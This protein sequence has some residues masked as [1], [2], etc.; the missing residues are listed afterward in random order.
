M[1]RRK[2][3]WCNIKKV[4]LKKTNRKLVKNNGIVIKDSIRKERRL[5]IKLEIDFK[6][7]NLENECSVEKYFGATSKKYI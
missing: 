7:I 6:K 1:Q 4:H 3:L 2:V 5:R